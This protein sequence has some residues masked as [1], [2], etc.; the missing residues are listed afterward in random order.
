LDGQTDDLS[1]DP[2]VPSRRDWRDLQRHREF[3]CGL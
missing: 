2:T 1:A 3:Y